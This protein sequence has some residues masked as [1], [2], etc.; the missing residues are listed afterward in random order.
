MGA[1]E[2]W[3]VVE[4]RGKGRGDY[5]EEAAPRQLHSGTR[6]PSS[7]IYLESREAESWELAACVEPG[8]CRRS[9]PRYTRA[10]YIGAATEC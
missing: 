10:S 7:N 4:L 1:E 6:G 3:E 8:T 9:L 5:K 2:S